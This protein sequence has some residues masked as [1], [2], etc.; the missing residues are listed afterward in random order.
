[1]A[2]TKKKSN[3]EM[4]AEIKTR[5][6]EMPPQNKPGRISVMEENQINQMEILS[7]LGVQQADIAR[8]LGFHPNSFANIMKNDLV[9]YEAYKRGN[10]KAVAK[11]AQTAY[12]MAVSGKHPSMTM[13]WLKAREKWREQHPDEIPAGQQVVFKTVI[14]TSGEITSTQQTIEDKK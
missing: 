8:I 13:F 1:M 14:G 6:G 11:V 7:G 9:A 2:K 4:L 3:D 12:Q 5:M 10:A